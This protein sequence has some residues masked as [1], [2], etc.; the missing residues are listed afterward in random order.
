MLLLLPALVLYLYLTRK[1]YRF[2]WK[3]VI[4]GLLLG[5]VPLLL[6]L[7][8]PLRGHI[9]SLD[10]AYQNTWAGFWQQVS[11]G[12]YGAFIF[13]N[14]FGHERDAAF[15]WSLVRGQFYALGPGFIGIFYLLWVGQRKMLLL[16]SVAL[17]T[18]LGFNLFYQV[19]DIEVFFIPVF[20]VWA[21]WSGVG[22]AFL[23][24]IT[25][26]MRRAGWRFSLTALVLMVF[27][28]MLVQ[29]IQTARPFLMDR[30]TWQVHDYGLDILRQPLDESSTIVGILGEMTL[31]RYFQQTEGLRPEVETI[32]ADLEADRLAAVE[33]LLGAGK[34]VYLTR[35]LPAAPERWAL[36]A[37]GPLIRV[38]PEP[39]KELP[40]GTI[41]LNQ[42]VTPEITLAGYNTFRTPHTGSGPA[43][44][45]LTLFWRVESPLSV[46]LKVS[47]RLLNSAGEAVAVTD[48]T[49]VHFAYPTTAWRSGEIVADVYDLSLPVDAPPGPYIP[50]LIWYD[51]AQNAA[52]VGRVE[53][54]PA[55]ID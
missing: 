3:T 12:G 43:P 47:A 9:G 54:G 50:L 14:P 29:N 45:R 26:G 28:F 53:L 25:G 34:S 6:Y 36:G 38:H 16:T 41:V 2:T 10:G 27:V 20:L 22:A 49:P 52:E 21:I 48:A 33:K 13:D 46:D 35:E 1:L 5:V 31:V 51:P 7:Y 8:L 19:S 4:V 32:A 23:L 30:N 24:Q 39:V 15:Y 17:L 55:V 42:P 37:V 18:Y 44:V 11:A 40:T